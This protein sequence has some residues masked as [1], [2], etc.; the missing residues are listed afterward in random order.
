MILLPEDVAQALALLEAHQK[1]AT[2]MGGVTR[3]KRKG[4][5]PFGT[6]K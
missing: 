1:K 6:L 3:Q 2:S 4:R 5:G